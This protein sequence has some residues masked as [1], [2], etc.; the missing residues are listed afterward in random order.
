[1]KVMK[2]FTARSLPKQGVDL[3]GGSRGG[4]APETEGAS[5]PQCT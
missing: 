5:Q 2:G 3:A 4:V 1:V